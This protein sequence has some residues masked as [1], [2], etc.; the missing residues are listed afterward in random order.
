MNE[1]KIIFSVDETALCWKKIPSRTSIAKEEKSMLDYG[2]SKDKMT[3]LLGA[4]T[5]GDLC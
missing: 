2:L 3:V 5:T 4:S 1:T